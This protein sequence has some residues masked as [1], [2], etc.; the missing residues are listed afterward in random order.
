[1]PAYK[2]IIMELILE[3]PSLYEKLRSGKRLLPA[4]DDYATLLKASHEEWKEQLSQSRPGSDPIQI[5]S[6]ALEIACKE[7]EERLASASKADEGEPLSL[8]AAMN[9]I[10]RH[11]PTA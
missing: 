11:T 7:L 8:D 4:I 9:F 6:E 5:A 10:R 3:Q 2:T 1:M